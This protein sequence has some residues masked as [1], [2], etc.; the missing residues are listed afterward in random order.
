MTPLRTDPTRCHLV[1][2]F[3]YFCNERDSDKPFRCQSWPQQVPNSVAIFELVAGR[4]RRPQPIRDCA[5][6]CD[7]VRNRISQNDLC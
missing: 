7:A 2:G 4:L 1:S 5:V 3:L 6:G